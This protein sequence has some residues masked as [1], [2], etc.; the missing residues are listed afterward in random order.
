M[1]RSSVFAAVLLLLLTAGFIRPLPARGSERHPRKYKSPPPM[2]HMVVTVVRAQDDKPLQHAAVVFHASSTG[3]DE[4]SIEMKTNEQGEATMNLIPVG[5]KVLVQ[6]I[7]PG[8]RTFGQ[9]YEVPGAEK[10]ITVKLL[11]PNEQY[12]VYVKSHPD[13]DIRTNA[14]QAQMGHAAPTDSPLLSPPEKKKKH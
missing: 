10:R 3:K 5:S 9:E 2:A 8:F 12:S 11:P 13:S 6:V 14:P 7:V 1:R 4:G